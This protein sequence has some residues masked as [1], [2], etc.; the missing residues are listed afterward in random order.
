MKHLALPIVSALAL[1]IAAC[2]PPPPP[3][4]GELTPEEGQPQPQPSPDHAQPQVDHSLDPVPAENLEFTPAPGDLPSF[5][6]LIVGETI[7]VTITVS[8]ASKGQ[9][10]FA[11]M[12]DERPKVL[13]VQPFNGSSTVTVEAPANYVGE[14]AV[15]ALSY[16]D[17]PMVSLAETIELAG[18]PIQLSLTIDQELPEPPPGEA[19]PPAPTS[20]GIDAAGTP[21]ADLP[22]DAAD[23]PAAATDDAEP[24]PPAGPPP[25]DGADAPAP[26][27]A[28][29]PPPPPNE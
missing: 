3:T 12:I 13:H 21:D 9:V 16:G 8:G 27:N 10:D 1:A 20:E 22:A 26:A 4:Q 11:Q 29:P 6:D 25:P 14:I 18:E 5:T 19:P 23:Q 24:T 2:A 7:T 28:G 17:N 15:S